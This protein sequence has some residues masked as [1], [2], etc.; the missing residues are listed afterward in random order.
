MEVYSIYRITNNVT[1]RVYVGRTL[2][3]KERLNGHWKCLRSGRHKIKELQ[4]DYNALGESAFTFSVI[5][6]MSDWQEASL[7]ERRLIRE[8]N[9]PYNRLGN[10][11]YVHHVTL[12]SQAAKALA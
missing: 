7:T 5:C 3:P 10:P 2:N 8:Q 6:E 4:D 1:G 11:N 12:R 9:N